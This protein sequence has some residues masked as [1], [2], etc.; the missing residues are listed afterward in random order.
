MRALHPRA[1]LPWPPVAQQRIKP[2]R[3]QLCMVS[4]LACLVVRKEKTQD[5]DA[6]DLVT[7][8]VTIGVVQDLAKLQ[9]ALLGSKRPTFHQVDA[10][11]KAPEIR[12]YATFRIQVPQAYMDK[13][14]WTRFKN[15]PATALLEWLSDKRLLHA[16]Y[17][18][19][20]SKQST[21]QGGAETYL[22]GYF[23]APV[24]DADSILFWSGH[25][26]VFV[27]RLVREVGARPHVEWIPLGNRTLEEYLVHGLH[28]SRTHKGGLAYR[29]GGGDALG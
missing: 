12:E 16:T 25:A 2:E 3:W 23:K 28:L 26:G 10:E 5:S 18:W 15:Q 17:G 29:P 14:A 19:C 27:E 6:A 13:E 11:A 22:L 24:K 4:T 8:P 7:L 21:R 9:C 20:E 1:W